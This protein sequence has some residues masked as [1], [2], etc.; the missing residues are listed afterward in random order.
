MMTD[1]YLAAILG[2]LQIVLPAQLLKRARYMDTATDSTLETV[3]AY[4]EMV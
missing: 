1:R 3:D 2:C 4:L